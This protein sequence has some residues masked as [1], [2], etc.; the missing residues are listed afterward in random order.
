MKLDDPYL[1]NV[2]SV[3]AL[4]VVLLMILAMLGLDVLIGERP[5]HRTLAVRPDRTGANVRI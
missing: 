2:L 5:L 3:G 1:A 4:M